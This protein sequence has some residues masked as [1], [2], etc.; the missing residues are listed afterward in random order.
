MLVRN[1][2]AHQRRIVYLQLKTDNDVSASKDSWP[3]GVCI[4]D[5]DAME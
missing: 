4:G 3:A 1:A 5:P 2:I